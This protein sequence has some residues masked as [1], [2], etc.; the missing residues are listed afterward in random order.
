MRVSNLVAH[1][2]VCPSAQRQ[3]H[4]AHAT[5]HVPVGPLAAL[6]AAPL[7]RNKHK[8]RWRRIGS[9]FPLCPYLLKPQPTTRTC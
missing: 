3:C 6:A 9:C 8:L 1:C 4:A 5:C 7:N 2:A